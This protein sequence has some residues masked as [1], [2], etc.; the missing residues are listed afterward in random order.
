MRA[1]QEIDLARLHNWLNAAHLK[2][3][4]MQ[5]PISIE[6]VSRKFRPRI[7]RSDSC[8]SLLA[9]QAG[10]PF[11]YIQWYLNRSVPEYGV[12]TI[13]EIDGVTFDYFI[14]D[15][16]YLGKGL[17]ASM[18]FSTIEMITE[19]LGLEDRIFFVG[20]EPKNKNAIKCSKRAGFIH[21]DQKNY[22][23]NGKHYQLYANDLRSNS[24]LDSISS[25][26]E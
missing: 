14:G 5:E 15:T 4:Y 8:H 18:L 24:P 2:P 3:F 12:A 13:G 20:H 19:L 11:G 10:V 21:Q 6:E 25:D 22:T 1:L 16:D 23:E 26:T 9:Y 17:G 7:E